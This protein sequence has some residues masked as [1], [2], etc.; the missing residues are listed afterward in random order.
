MA[1]LSSQASITPV[2][3]SSFQIP[4]FHALPSSVLERTPVGGA[5]DS[6]SYTPTGCVKTP[7]KKSQFESET[8]W[9]RAVAK[10]EPNGIA[11]FMPIFRG[12]S[13]A[14]NAFDLE[15]VTREFDLNTMSVADYKLGKRSYTRH[16]SRVPDER[17]TKK[18]KEMYKVDWY[19]TA[20]D[21]SKSKSK[22]K[23]KRKSK[24]NNEH[25]PRSVISSFTSC[26]SISSTT[27]SI[28][29]PTPS[30]PPS[31]YDYMKWRDNT[32]TS[33]TLGFRLTAMR[34]KRLENKNPEKVNTYNFG[35]GVDTLDWTKRQASLNA[36]AEYSLRYF[37]GG[38]D[39][40]KVRASAFS[41]KLMEFAEVMSSS[42]LLRT[43]EIIG[44]SILL[45]YD[46]SQG[47]EDNVCVKWIDFSHVHLKE[48]K[49]VEVVKDEGKC[50]YIGPDGIIEGVRNL[51][52]LLQ[53][54]AEKKNENKY[55]FE[56]REE[57]NCGCSWSQGI[58]DVTITKFIGPNS[59]STAK[60]NVVLSKNHVQILIQNEIVLD[61]E[62]PHDVDVRS[63]NWS[64]DRE[65]GEILID[66]S[67]K[68]DGYWEQVFTDGVTIDIR[69]LG[70]KVGD[71][72]KIKDPNEP[73]KI[74]DP[75]MI[76]QVAKEHPEIAAAMATT[77][78]GGN[79]LTT[80]KST[81][82]T[83]QGQSSFAW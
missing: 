82:A 5:H 11:K 9:Y 83:F 46:L 26:A 48:T 4:V 50:N 41:K 29:A 38:D 62:L 53:Q 76:A 45:C 77:S 28:P 51:A 33:S 13:T 24:S 7:P 75:E 10:H 52:T 19:A 56:T 30:L 27:S 72:G 18:L 70:P 16:V 68:I 12:I 8:S 2:L 71:V 59:T 23:G 74:E 25:L 55:E 17:Y 69:S 21:E 36:A 14:N 81:S 43:H 65:S 22:S 47:N 35:K 39:I 1:S 60:V 58:S 40:N 15:D 63:S 67:K 44:S 66:L 54:I 34:V 79:E 37:L 32:S 6:I 3:H 80:Q 31:K 61:K 49:G 20:T 64:V 78:G 57:E 73:V 42:L